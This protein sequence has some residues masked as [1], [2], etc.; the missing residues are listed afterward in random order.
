M[1]I[2]PADL[3]TIAK[4]FLR[5]LEQENVTTCQDLERRLGSRHEIKGTRDFISFTRRP[6]DLNTSTYTIS[7]VR[8]GTGVPIELKINA[9]LDYTNIILKFTGRLQN[10]A[11]FALDIFDNLIQNRILRSSEMPLLKQELHQLSELGTTK[12]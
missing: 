11:P 12:Q 7:Y 3:A 10:Y 5:L 8:E 2:T 9:D 1:R 6:S 4:S